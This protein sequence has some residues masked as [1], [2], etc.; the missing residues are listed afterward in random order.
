[1][2]AVNPNERLLKFLQATAEQRAAIDRILEGRTGP[3]PEPPKGPL[4]LGMGAGANLLGVS[5][6]TFWRIIK[7]GK[8]SKVEVLPGSFRVRR[9]DVEG[10]AAGHQAGVRVPKVEVA[11]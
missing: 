1:M 8:L 10:L 11:T 4:L 5:R 3:A 9:A 6:A 2:T 7:A